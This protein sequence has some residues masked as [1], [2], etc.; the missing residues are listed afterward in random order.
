MS[1]VPKKC[2]D[3]S[4]GP[5]ASI[6]RVD[7]PNRNVGTR[8]IVHSIASHK[9][10]TNMPSVWFEGVQI[11]LPCSSDAVG[12]FCDDWVRNLKNKYWQAD[13]CRLEVGRNGHLRPICGTWMADFVSIRGPLLSGEMCACRKLIYVTLGYPPYTW[14]LKC[15]YEIKQEYL[16]AP[17]E[18][19]LL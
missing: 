15:R 16:A 12:N 18:K 1:V 11:F 10:S 6:F 5:A 7:E 13:V 17:N 8:T 3:V 2:V 4:E 19:W 14:R 9:T